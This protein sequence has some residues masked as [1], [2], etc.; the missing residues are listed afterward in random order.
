MDAELAEYRE[1]PALLAHLPYFRVSL[2]FGLH[3]GWSY[4]GASKICEDYRSRLDHNKSLWKD[5]TVKMAPT[6][7]QRL[8][9]PS[10]FLLLQGAIGQSPR[11]VRHQPDNPLP[12]TDPVIKRAHGVQVS[13]AIFC[14]ICRGFTKG[15]RICVLK[16]MVSTHNR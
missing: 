6:H 7:T 1:H 4:E 10:L 5:G 14:D 8:P 12:F 16:L 9:H 15:Y 11:G 13:W 2:G 3:L